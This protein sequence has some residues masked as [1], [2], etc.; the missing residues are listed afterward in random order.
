MSDGGRGGIC[1][2]IFPSVVLSDMFLVY[3]Y[4]R[5]CVCDTYSL[6]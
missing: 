5:K 6:K 2:F 4:T 3:I 1:L